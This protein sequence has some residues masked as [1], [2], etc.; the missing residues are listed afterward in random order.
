M[1]Q[2][3]KRITRADARVAAAEAAAAKARAEAEAAEAEAARAEAEAAAAEAA[4]ASAAARITKVCRGQL[5]RRKTQPVLL[6]RRAQAKAQ[7]ERE[8]AKR[9]A[10]R[11][12]ERRE[13]ALAAL[14]PKKPWVGALEDPN[15]RH[16]N[17]KPTPEILAAQEAWVAKYGDRPVSLPREPQG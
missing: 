13:A 10:A 11:R 15:A 1:P 9:A 8:R 2:P 6:E 3:R 16:R 12:A 5:A 7:A 4:Q 17:P 14:G